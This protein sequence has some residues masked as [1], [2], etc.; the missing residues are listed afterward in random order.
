M[1]LLFFLQ[2]NHVEDEQEEDTGQL[3]K[4]EENLNIKISNKNLIKKLIEL[5]LQQ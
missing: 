4:V 2:I 1:Y 5:K 3:F